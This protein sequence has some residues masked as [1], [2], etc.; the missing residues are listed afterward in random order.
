MNFSKH[1]I[2]SVLALLIGVMSVIAGSRV[3]LGISTP[4][5]NILQWMVLYNVVVGIVSIA[6]SILIWLKNQ[7]MMFASL[8][9]AAAHTLVLILLVSVFSEVAADESMKAML[10]R[11]GIWT[12]IV[13]LNIKTNRK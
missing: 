6:V 2:A 4:D 11:V 7:L 5:Y 3:L 8:M 12:T 13:I 1:K 10:F 9:I